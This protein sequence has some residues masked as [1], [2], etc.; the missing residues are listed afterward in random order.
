MV[1]VWKIR[2]YKLL[3]YK[4]TMR[5]GKGNHFAAGLSMRLGHHCKKQRR[6]RFTQLV[7]TCFGSA[8]AT[9]M[10]G[11]IPLIQ[12]SNRCFIT[13]QPHVPTN[14]YTCLE[15]SSPHVSTCFFWMK[16][17]HAIYIYIHQNPCICRTKNLDTWSINKIR[18]NI[19]YPISWNTDYLVEN[20]FPTQVAL[21]ISSGNLLHSYWKTVYSWFTY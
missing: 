10:T 13:R 1:D 18:S 15:T 17:H 7:L 3:Y 2:F 20:G 12:P 6:R 11:A 16:W 14:S 9:K 19:I 5:S 8:R 21:F 4:P